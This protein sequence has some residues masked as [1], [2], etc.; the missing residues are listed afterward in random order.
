M[1]GKAT[2][3]DD[4]QYVCVCVLM[5]VNMIFMLCMVGSSINNQSKHEQFYCETKSTHAKVVKIKT[6]SDRD[7]A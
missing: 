7:R 6:F 1:K 4:V 2:K 3:L 5:S